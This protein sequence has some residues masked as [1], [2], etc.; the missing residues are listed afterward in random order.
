MRRAHLFHAAHPPPSPHTAYKLTPHPETRRKHKQP[1]RLDR[2]HVDKNTRRD[3]ERH[4]RGQFLC[5]R[6]QLSIRQ[7]NL[8][9]PPMRPLRIH[10][11]RHA[12]IAHPHLTLHLAKRFDRTRK[13]AHTL[14]NRPSKNVVRTTSVG[15][16]HIEINDHTPRT[17]PERRIQR[18]LHKHTD[19][20][21]CFLQHIHIALRLTQT[22]IRRKK[23]HA[24]AQALR[25][26]PYHRNFPPHRRIHRHDIVLPHPVRIQK[27]RHPSHQ[28][29][30]LGRRPHRT[31]PR[32]H[33]RIQNPGQHHPI[34]RTSFHTLKR[35]TQKWTMEF[36]PERIALFARIVFFFRFHRFLKEHLRS[37]RPPTSPPSHPKANPNFS[38]NNSQTAHHHSQNTKASAL[39][40]L[41]DLKSLSIP[42]NAAP[43]LTPRLI[44]CL[45]NS[46]STSNT[47]KSPL[48]SRPTK[49]RER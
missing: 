27:I 22:P 15:R 16:F 19:A 3:I 38:T 11:G 40:P 36:L 47:K 21:A 39:Q 37:K 31:H 10:H 14:G 34:R 25:R 8:T 13:T 2:R 4:Q 48:N 42:Q 7:R 30:H 33:P 45:P 43:I 32:P 26:H 17:A 44:T 24:R 12:F 28:R 20:R 5:L 41:K 46:P 35:R 29:R 9:Y 23:Q 1:H 6:R 18:I 49:P